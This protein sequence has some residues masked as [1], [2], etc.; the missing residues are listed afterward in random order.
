MAKSLIYDRIKFNKK[1]VQRNFILRS[2]KS[3]KI[4]GVKLAKKLGIGQ[5]TL[6]DW[7]K[8]KFNMSYVAAQTLSKISE[9]PFPSSHRVIKWNDHLKKIGKLGGK[10]RVI[11]YGKVVLDEE[12]RNMKWKEWWGKVGQYKKKPK[13]FQT[14]IKIKK[15]KRSELLAEF[16]GIM[17]GDG[18]INKYH[19]SVTLS[20]KEKKYILFVSKVIKKLFCVT[21]KIHKLSY[22]KA[23]QI[24]VNRK[25]LADFCHEIGL[26]RGNK[27][28]QMVDIPTWIKENKKFSIACIRGLVDTD[29][30]FYTNSY[31]SNGKKYSYFKIA[32]VSASKTLIDSVAKILINSGINFRVDRNHRDV[33]IESG[34]YV[35]KYIKEIGSHNHKHL[36]KIKKAGIVM[37]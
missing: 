1:G 31:Y 21:P 15:P 13:N 19:I 34:Q 14:I 6:S 5:R 2:K 9:V 25:Q 33:R 23:V 22:A 24:V 18:G 11:L 10:N 30:C 12:Y 3:L 37:D 27:V 32:F 7:T 28:N 16:V 8:E 20:D 26:V 4:T 17:L 29:G 35:S 36:E